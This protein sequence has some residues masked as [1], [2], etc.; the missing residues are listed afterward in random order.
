MV[1]STPNFIF[2]FSEACCIYDYCTILG[3]QYLASPV[4][5]FQH[6]FCVRLRDEFKADIICSPCR[7]DQS[8]HLKIALRWIHVDRP[9][10]SSL[11]QNVSRNFAKRDILCA[12]KRHVPAE[13]STTILRNAR[14]RMRVL[15][16]SGFLLCIFFK[17]FM[18]AALRSD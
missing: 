14:C 13:S 17:I 9:P 18:A 16:T 15:A 7:T 12:P 4:K 3:M 10:E 2:V 11:A 1:H 6:S 5:K 8:M